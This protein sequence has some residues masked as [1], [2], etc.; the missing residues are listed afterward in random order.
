MI[1]IALE[2]SRGGNESEEHAC[3]ITTTSF[4]PQPSNSK[5]E[6]KRL[7]SRQMHMPLQRRVAPYSLIAI[8]GAG[9]TA[10]SIYSPEVP[11]WDNFTDDPY[12][13]LRGGLVIPL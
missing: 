1:R 11:M 4:D 8:Q 12:T 5:P 6:A 7:Q 3:H 9:Y 10:N 13:T 2:L